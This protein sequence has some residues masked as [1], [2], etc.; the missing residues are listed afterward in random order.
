MDSSIVVKISDPVP[1]D[2]P[3][4]MDVSAHAAMGPNSQDFRFLI[5]KDGAKILQASIFDINNNPFKPDLDKLKTTGAPSI[6]TPGAP[7]VLV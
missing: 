5:S 6:G 4:F 1:S 3:G 7:V 2:V